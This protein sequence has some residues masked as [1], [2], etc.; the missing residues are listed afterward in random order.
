MPLQAVFRKTLV[1]P[2]CVRSFEITLAAG[3][4]WQV[5]ERKDQDVVRQHFGD[6]HRVERVATRLAQDV[7]ALQ[8]DGWEEFPN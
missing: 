7:A 8:R 2:P 3:T 1:R 6:W 5:F 4:G